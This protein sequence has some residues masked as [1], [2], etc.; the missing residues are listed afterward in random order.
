MQLTFAL[1]RPAPNNPGM[2]D[3]RFEEREAQGSA[4]PSQKGPAR[5]RR[6]ALADWLA[7]NEGATRIAVLVVAV[8]AMAAGTLLWATGRLD[9]QNVGYAGALVINLIGSATVLIPVPGLAVVCGGS[10]EQAA[11]NPVLLGLAGGVGS[12]V[13]EMSGYLAGYTGRSLLERSRHYA[14][15][16]G[17]VQRY[18]GL[19]LFVLSAVPNPVFD[20]AGIAAGSLGYSVRRFL[21]YVLA[22]KLVKYVAVVYACRSGI[23]WLVGLG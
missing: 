22:G 9:V 18:G 19:P 23:D 17:W 2:A 14:R 3:G 7:A 13:G 5:G 4:T 6:T 15:I 12:A 10:V 20:V 11:L 16:H 1:P 21:F 8:A